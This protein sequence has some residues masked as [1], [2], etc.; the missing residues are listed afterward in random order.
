MKHP[1]RSFVLSLCFLALVLLAFNPH[2]VVKIQT[3]L[4][5]LPDKTTLD[6]PAA[7]QKNN[8]IR[9][10]SDN[11]QINPARLPKTAKP[12]EDNLPRIEGFNKIAKNDPWIGEAPCRTDIFDV[13][14]TLPRLG[15]RQD[16]GLLTESIIANGGQKISNQPT[17]IFESPNGI[18]LKVVKPVVRYYTVTGPRFKDAKKDIFDR[19]PLE[20]SD[21][22]SADINKSLDTRKT[23]TLAHISSPTSLSYMTYGSG[24]N[25][26]LVTDK[27]ELTSAFLVTLPRWANYTTASTTDKAK[28]DDLLCNASHHELG[29]LR[30][31]LDIL[32]ETLD[33]YALLP[34][35]QPKAE[36]IRE[37]IAYRK[38]VNARVEE[39]Q[40]AYHI[41]NGGGLRRGMTELPYAELPFPWLETDS[42][43]LKRVEQLPE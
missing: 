27:V 39:R 19:K 38:D 10:R 18:T 16:S 30:I 7:I 22:K 3:A 1:V 33:G 26:R 17:Y 20:T 14:L 41:Y 2:A 34:I 31:R 11:P 9:P 12:N 15:P 43:N 6:I 25:Y 35:G 23:T 4:G 29:H 36:I 5:L 40:D 32:S 13:P 28:W 37:T 21:P 8:P 24:E 42:P